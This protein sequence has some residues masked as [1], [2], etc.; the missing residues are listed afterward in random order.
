MPAQYS[1]AKQKAAQQVV[2][3]NAGEL[4][5]RHIAQKRHIE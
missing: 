5:H 2:L 3:T 1:F 4:N